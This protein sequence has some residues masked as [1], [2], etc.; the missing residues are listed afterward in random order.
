M[1]GMGGMGGG[2]PGGGMG[3]MGGRHDV[4]APASFPNYP[5]STQYTVR[6]NT[7]IEGNNHDGQ[8]EDSTVG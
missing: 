1:G 7:A 6:N 5:Q 4:G 2:M 8:D 3:G